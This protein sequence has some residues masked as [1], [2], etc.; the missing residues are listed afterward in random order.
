LLEEDQDRIY[1]RVSDEWFPRRDPRAGGTIYIWTLGSYKTAHAIAREFGHGQLVDVLMDRT[2]DALKLVLACDGG[3]ERAVRELL[4]RRPALSAE[5]PAGERRR[6]PDAAER[7]DLAAVRLYLEAGWPLNAAAKHGA[8]ALHWAAFH[9]NSEMT[10]LLLARGASV[11]AKDSDFEGTP[12]G[13]AQH[14]S[15]HGWHRG[16]GNYDATKAL[17]IGAGAS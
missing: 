14:G 10:R 6:L 1:T 17:L 5:I 12:L 2:P 13:W 3:D 4:S 15:V 9:G 11:Q 7:N 16:Q 8:T